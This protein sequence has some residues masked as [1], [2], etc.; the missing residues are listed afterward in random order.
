MRWVL[1]P[2]PDFV[3]AYL[4]GLAAWASLVVVLFLLAS[5]SEPT[6]QGGLLDGCLGIPAWIVPLGWLL[7]AVPACSIL[8]A[9]VALRGYRR[10]D[11]LGRAIAGL[12]LSV[13]AGV[14][15]ASLYA[16]SAFPG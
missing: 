12:G 4:L 16:T 7:V 15:F 3:L 1:R 2:L 5:E 14:A 9:V 13:S 6:C 10:G 11:D 8:G